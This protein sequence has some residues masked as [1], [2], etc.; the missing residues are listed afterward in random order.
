MDI[1][2][3]KVIKTNCK[4]NVYLCRFAD[5]F[6]CSFEYKEDAER[7]YNDL[8]IRLM[9]FGLE[10]AEDKTKIITFS[11]NKKKSAGFDFLGFEF[12]WT[13]S[14]K[15]K[16]FVCK[17]TSRKKL[18]NSIRNMSTW[19]KENRSLRLR[20]LFGLL[21]VKLRGYYNYYGV[22]GNYKSLELFYQQVKKLLYKWLNRRS[23]KSSFNWEVF[24]EILA[25]YELLKP[26][27]TQKL[28]KQLKFVFA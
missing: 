3:D 16:W 15:G 22:I 23:Q 19:R 6:V 13:K 21:N 26:R 27:I 18:I 17:K 24:N 1:R 14:R 25:Y 4:G 11:R 5:D 2:F 7:F 9:K 20:K 10:V 28:D 12:R 8:P